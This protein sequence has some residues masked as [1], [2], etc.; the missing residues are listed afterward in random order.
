VNLGYTEDVAAVWGR[1]QVSGRQVTVVAKQ[2]WQF[3]KI[4]LTIQ[5]INIHGRNGYL[6]FEE[7]LTSSND[8]FNEHHVS[9]VRFEVPLEPFR[10]V[11]DHRL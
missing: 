4:I 7:H 6:S 8:E 11:A 3:V 10:F 1:Y 9:T 5:P 2:P